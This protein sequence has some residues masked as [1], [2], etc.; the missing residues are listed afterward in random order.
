MDVK[1]YRIHLNKRNG[2]R[3]YQFP[4]CWEPSLTVK[5]Y[6]IKGFTCKKLQKSEFPVSCESVDIKFFKICSIVSILLLF[7]VTQSRRS[8]RRLWIK[9]NK[10]KKEPKWKKIFLILDNP[11]YCIDFGFFGTKRILGLQGLSSGWCPNP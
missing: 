9:I 8:S 5:R 2:R 3:I 11:S 6:L 7:K 1:P 4:P 10:N